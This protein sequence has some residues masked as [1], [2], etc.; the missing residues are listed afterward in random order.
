MLS[1]WNKITLKENCEKD[2]SS[3]SVNGLKR[4]SGERRCTLCR[5]PNLLFN[6]ARWLM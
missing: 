6:K 5:T 2:L 3:T 1:L 4:M